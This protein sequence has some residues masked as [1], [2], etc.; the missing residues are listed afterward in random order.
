MRESTNATGS[1]VAAL[2]LLLLV[3]LTL[4]KAAVA[5]PS[6]PPPVSAA[7]TNSALQISLPDGATSETT[8]SPNP[9][10]AAAPAA[11]GAQMPIVYN[12]GYI[13]HR[14]HV[15]AIFWGSEWNEN[16]A[17]REKLLNLYRTIPGSS[18][19]KVLTQYFDQNGYFSGETDLTSYTDTAVKRPPA[20]NSEAVR[21]EIN[22]SIETHPEWGSPNYENQYVV[23]TPPGTPGTYAGCAYHG[24]QGTPYGISFSYVPWSEESCRRGLVPPES[25]EVSAS[26]EW[27]ES[28]IDP[29]PIGEYWGWAAFS[30][31]GEVGDLCNTQTPAEHVE[32][33]SGLWVAKLA[34]DYLWKATGA[35]CVG[36]DDSPIRYSWAS[37]SPSIGLHT[38]RLSGNVTP[39]GYPAWH[40]FELTGP[41]GTQSIP[42]RCG[43]PYERHY[44]FA[45]DGESFSNSEVSAD[46]AGLK[47]GT[48]Y[49]VRLSSVSRLTEPK[50]SELAGG[51]VIMA[52]N[53]IQFTTPMWPP[54]VATLPATS[55]ESTHAILNGTVDPQGEPTSYYFEYGTTTS[56][57]QATP[58]GDAGAGVG[59]VPVEYNLTG[60]KE[61]T[62][63]HFRIRATNQEGTSYGSDQAFRTPG[64]PIFDALSTRYTT[65]VEPEFTASINPNGAATH[66][67]FEYGLTAAYGSKVPAAPAEIG[68]GL[69]DVQVGHYIGPLQAG[70]NYH[71]RLVAQNVVGTTATQDSTFTTPPPCKGAE[72][73]CAWANQTTVDPP[74][75]TEDEFKGISCPGATLCLAVGRN[76]FAK[77]SFL[78]QWNGSAWTLQENL[79]GEMRQIACASTTTCVAVGV[80]GSGVAN[81]WMINQVGG[82]WSANAVAP[83]LPGG[84]TQSTLSGVSCNAT[85]CTAVGSYRN[86]EGTYRPLV[87][88]WNGSTWSLQEAPN[89]PEG[90]AQNAMLS[91]SCP[92]S[93]FCV[94]AGEAAAKP[95]TELWTGSSWMTA[96][97]LLPSG[98]STGKLASVSCI[99]SVACTFVGSS[100]EKLGGEKT[101]VERWN[102][103]SLSLQ[104]SPNPTEAQGFVNLTSVSC[105]SSS[106]CTAVGYYASKVGGGQATEV[107]TLAERWD[108]SAW[109][110]KSTPNS[111]ASK[112]SALAGVSCPS[113]TACTAAGL[114]EPGPAG[115][116]EVTL[117]ESWNGSAWS[118]QTTV[119]PAPRTEDELKDV[120]CTGPSS[121]LGIGWNGYAKNSFIE[122]WNGAAWTLMQSMQG[123]V[124]GISCSF[125]NVCTAVG[126]SSGIAQT[127]LLNQVS[128][129]GWTV[130]PVAPPLPAG[131][132]QTGFNDIYCNTTICVAVGSYR[133]SEGSYRPLVEQLTSNGWSLKEAPNP[134]EGTAQKAMLAVSCGSENSCAAVGEAAGKPVAETWNGTSWAR[135]SLPSLPPGAITGRFASVSCP[136]SDSCFA[137]GSSAEK[138]EA[139][140]PL[141][142]SWNGTSWAIASVPS[143]AD[144]KGLVALSSISC[145][146]PRACF[147]AGS[148]APKV[149]GGVAQESKP[150]VESLAAGQW[151]P[152]TSAPVAG[153]TFSG[154]AGIYCTS[155]VACTTIGAKSTA[156]QGQPILTLA[157]R[158]E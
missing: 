96:W 83:P 112:N 12:G 5:L 127:W 135:A 21:A 51:P 53:D 26:H 77:N 102:G 9:L 55:I 45:L 155:V 35:E 98:A 99:S 113:M 117:A 121:C 128:E 36:H 115:E 86:A 111:P 25:M 152:Q 37:N 7:T 118:T 41:N 40:D 107:K 30:E 149:E 38:A 146:S 80:G 19:A 66:Y 142:E 110:I 68:A 156:R 44:C 91:V 16:S 140:K 145:L 54:I 42:A 81:T 75:F 52:G 114:G 1:L 61:A 157:E 70:A 69:F 104:G 100:A 138:P 67:Q 6:S 2:T 103:F 62:I 108:G 147:A 31:Q 10:G 95:V 18:Y 143:P 29:I 79:G 105:P 84:A 109:A 136:A 158:Y 124:N 119:N 148:Y 28:A 4:P 150:L 59:A 24:W 144:A 120:T 134:A 50:I 39:G 60:L 125:T 3:A 151:S 123:E 97:G 64:K 139:E 49:H 11:V 13:Q 141:V 137:A 27:A 23:F 74:P 63:Y 133:N 116:A 48:T 20:P 90:S 131:A 33:S 132:T 129:T 130:S 76:A 57:G 15:F 88:R 34:D 22:H 82:G 78:E 47:G 93:N 72:S 92:A 17:S 126:V 8:S 43:S 85:S 73:K 153:F 56:Y 87:E 65:T 46:V 14:P 94:A 154:L 32:L 89:P 122:S 106:S 58:A 101:L 71:F